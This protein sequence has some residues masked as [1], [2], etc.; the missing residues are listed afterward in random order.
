MFILYLG[1][2]FMEDE[3]NWKIKPNKFLNNSVIN[4]LINIGYIIYFLPVMTGTLCALLCVVFVILYFFL[5][6]LEELLF[7]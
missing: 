6:G 7:S 3:F 1:A 4:T 5:I 2:V